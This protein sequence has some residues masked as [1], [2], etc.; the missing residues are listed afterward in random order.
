MDEQGNQTVPPGFHIIYLPFTEDIRCIKGE[1]KHNP[2]E[3]LVEKSKEIIKKLQFAYH[4]ELFE[5]P[6]I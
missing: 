3:A 2:S 6:G 4:P 1:K 5:N